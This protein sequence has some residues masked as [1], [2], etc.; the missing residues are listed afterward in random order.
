[1]GGRPTSCKLFFLINFF[2]L[3]NPLQN[4]PRMENSVC[5]VYRNY[6]L[7]MKLFVRNMYRIV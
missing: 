7:M 6:L 3:N 5:Y 1:M 4:S 2:Q